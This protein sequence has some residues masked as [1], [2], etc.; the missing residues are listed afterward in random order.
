MTTQRVNC[1]V[2]VP[3]HRRLGEYANAFR[4]LADTGPEFL[5]DFLVYSQSERRAT[6]VAR[7]RMHRD[8]LETVREQLNGAMTEIQKGQGI[9]MILAQGGGEVH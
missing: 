6:V 7:V 1:D 4:I 3:P 5:L 8:S 2:R 9:P